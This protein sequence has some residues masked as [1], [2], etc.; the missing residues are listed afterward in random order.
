M[1]I[2][3]MQEQVDQQQRQQGLF[4][5]PEAPTLQEQLD[6]IDRAFEEL[7]NK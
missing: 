4:A 1:P 5:M 6:A 7:S 3:T 2:M